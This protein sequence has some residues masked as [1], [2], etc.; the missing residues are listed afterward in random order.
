M[1][2]LITGQVGNNKF[3]QAG[4]CAVENDHPACL[5]YLCQQGL[6]VHRNL[7]SKVVGAALESRSTR[8]LQVLLDRGWDI[9]RPEAYREPPFMG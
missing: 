2:D 5:A 6:K 3:F 4:C 9:N 8:C 1:P 7:V